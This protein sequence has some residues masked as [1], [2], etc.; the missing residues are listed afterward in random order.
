MWFPLAEL[1]WYDIIV[2]Y[3][4]KD[5]GCFKE[6]IWYDFQC[7]SR[8]DNFN[9]IYVFDFIFT[10]YLSIR[11]LFFHLIFFLK[12]GLKVDWD[13]YMP[14]PF[15]QYLIIRS[16]ILPQRINWISLNSATLFAFFIWQQHIFLCSLL[17]KSCQRHS[18]GLN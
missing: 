13:I 17:P 4:I 18:L 14:L 9:T 8:I 16:Q 10:E 7:R 15:N 6:I 2:H 12:K 5:F 1:K 3:Q 11:F